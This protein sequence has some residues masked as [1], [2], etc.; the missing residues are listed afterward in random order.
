[1]VHMSELVRKKGKYTSFTPEIRKSIFYALYQFARKIDASY[2][3]IIID[4][5]YYDNEERFISRLK[6]EIME[7]VDKNKE[8]FNKFQRID[9]YYDNGQKRLRKIFAQIFWQY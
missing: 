9:F 8:Y 3:S 1:M 5:T 2:H 4:K 6:L 7:F